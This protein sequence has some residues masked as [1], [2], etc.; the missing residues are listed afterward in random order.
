MSFAV[1]LHLSGGCLVKITQEG[2][3]GNQVGRL[4]SDAQPVVWN[5]IC[6]YGPKYR[7]SSKFDRQIVRYGPPVLVGSP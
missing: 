4:E 1:E 6:V 3:V 7:A 2:K 5:S